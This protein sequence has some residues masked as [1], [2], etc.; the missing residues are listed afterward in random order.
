VWANAERRVK[1]SIT[2]ADAH[3]RARARDAEG[4]ALRGFAAEAAGLG[5]KNRSA[6]PASVAVVRR[7][8]SWRSNGHGKPEKVYFVIARPKQDDCKSRQKITQELPLTTMERDG[9]Q[10]HFECIGCLHP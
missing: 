2:G 10:C 8:Q 3:R 4:L 9:T 1:G 6:E 5:L 7:K